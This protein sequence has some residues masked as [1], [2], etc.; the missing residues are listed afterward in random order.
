MARAGAQRP[1]IRAAIPLV[2]IGAVL[3]AA[4][5][6]GAW[7]VHRLHKRGT[8]ILSENVA[9]IRAAEEFETVM[10]ETRLRIKRYLE[11]HDARQLS[12]L[13]QLLASGEQSLHESHALSASVQEKQLMSNAQQRYHYLMTQYRQAVSQEG[14]ESRDEVLTELADDVIPNQLLVYSGKYVRLNEGQL[15]RSQ[16]RNQAT[17]NRLMFGLLMLGTCGGVAGLLA[18]YGIARLVNRTIFQLAIPLRTAAGTLNQVAGPVTVTADPG[19]D[20]IESVLNSV[21]DH[22]TDVVARLQ[23]SERDRLRA[24]Q[25]AA[26]GQLAAGL[27][28]E[29]RNPLTSMKAILQMAERPSDLSARD[30][31]ILLEESHRLEQSIQSLLDF[32]RPPSPRKLPTPLAETL[33]QTVSLVRRQAE[34]KGTNL[35]FVPTG[36][37]AYLLADAA[38]LRQVVLNLLLNAIEFTP[39]DG[40]VRL[41]CRFDDGTLPP[42][43]DGLAE[44]GRQEPAV[45]HWAVIRIY[46]TG[47]GLPEELGPRIF[48]PFVTTKETGTGLG[49]S[50]CKQI[51]D[52]HGG[53]LT[54]RN[55]TTGGAVFEVRLPLT[56]PPRAI[57]AGRI[58]QPHEEALA[59]AGQRNENQA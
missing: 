48:D 38:Q 20:D 9:S 6:Y 19:F 33:E 10:Q 53:Q 52:S 17:A 47:V 56:C 14:T 44:S 22:V 43:S 3:L 39:R 30:L 29:L 49:L 13:D 25:L 4:G 16:Q 54:C 26:L 18:G 5:T 15:D 12:Q 55:R 37:E 59:A 51:V 28:H 31:D 40:A 34:R 36:Q 23:E 41:E 1:F 32:A 27:A 24:E 11:S 8:D 42:A 57:S 58:E 46:D 50:I 35:C 2:A 21:S 7:R 45:A